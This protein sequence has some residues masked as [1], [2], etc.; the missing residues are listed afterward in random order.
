MTMAEAIDDLGEDS[1]FSEPM[2]PR[3]GGGVRYVFTFSFT[4]SFVDDVKIFQ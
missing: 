2:W 4:F 1:P 3:G